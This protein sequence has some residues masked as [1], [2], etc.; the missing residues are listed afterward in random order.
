[1]HQETVKSYRLHW[2]TDQQL[3][4]TLVLIRY[5]YFGIS[6]SCI[7]SIWS[8]SGFIERSSTMIEFLSRFHILSRQFGHFEECWRNY[9]S[10]DDGDTYKPCLF[11]TG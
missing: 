1:M 2:P 11:E 6:V 9:G 3:C 4:F 8:A 7:S 10:D 5:H